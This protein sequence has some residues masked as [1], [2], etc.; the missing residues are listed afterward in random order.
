M[1]LQSLL[2]TMF[3]INFHANLSMRTNPCKYHAFV[4]FR[5]T[6]AGLHCVSDALLFASYGCTDA[7]RRSK[8]PRRRRKSR[9]QDLQEG[10]RNTAHHALSCKSLYQGTQFHLPLLRIM[11]LSAARQTMFIIN[12]H[13]N[14][15]MCTKPRK[16]HALV[17]F[18][19]PPEGLHCPSGALFFGIVGHGRCRQ[20]L[21]EASP[22]V[23]ERKQA[24]LHART[25]HTALPNGFLVSAPRHGATPLCGTPRRKK[26]SERKGQREREI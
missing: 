23:G 1:H 19:R 24:D 13:V 26:K 3:I 2:Q 18:R 9:H 6:P 4:A 11:P 20:T 14:L 5:R 7:A 10:A 17:A 25:R 21:K 15:S 8:K 16:H 12:C 22:R